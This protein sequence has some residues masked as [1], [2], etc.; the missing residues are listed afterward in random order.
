MQKQTL[1]PILTEEDQ[2]KILDYILRKIIGFSGK[3]LVIGG[4]V[5]GGIFLG[6]LGCLKLLEY[7]NAPINDGLLNT[8][9]SLFH[10]FVR[11][12]TSHP[13]IYRRHKLSNGLWQLLQAHFPC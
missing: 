6:A 3:I 10:Q 5:V 4:T 1:I 7:K 8:F 11:W 9:I 2:K 12:L 13:K